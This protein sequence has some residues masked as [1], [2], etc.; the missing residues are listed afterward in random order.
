MW[1]KFINKWHLKLY[2]HNPTGES[3]TNFSEGVYFGNWFRLKRR[4][5]HSKWYTTH[6]P[7]V[8]VFLSR[9]FTCLN[10]KTLLKCV[11]ILNYDGLWKSKTLS[12]ENQRFDWIKSIHWYRLVNNGWLTDIDFFILA[13][14]SC[15]FIIIKNENSVRGHG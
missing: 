8:F 5:L 6:L 7:C 1:Q 2:H 10:N 14:L 12:E 4:G 13:D 11:E 15:L 9:L 3:V